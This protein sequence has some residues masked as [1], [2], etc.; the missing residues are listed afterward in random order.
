MAPL[1]CRLHECLGRS[2]L[3]WADMCNV[4]NRTQTSTHKAQSC[5]MSQHYGLHMVTCITRI[6]GSAGAAMVPSAV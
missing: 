4:V 1:S 6:W 3:R 2:V 5:F